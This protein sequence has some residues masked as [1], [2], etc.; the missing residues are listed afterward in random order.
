M[1]TVAPFGAT[2]PDVTHHLADVNGTRLHYVSAGTTG[3]PVLL[4]HGWPET[5]WAFRGLI[6]RLAL[7][8]RVVAVD[9]RGFGDSGSGDT[10]YGEAVSAEDLRQLVRHLGAGP[11]HLLCQDISG[12]TGFRFAAGHPEDVLSFTG[13]ETTLAGYGL[14]ALAD[15]NRHGSWHVGFL[16]A[17]G[18]PSMLL[19]G[20]ERELLAGW[21]FPLMSGTEGAITERDVDEFTRTYARPGGWRGTE[22]LYQAVFADGGATRER[23]EARPLQVP[24][25]AVDGAAHPFTENTLRQVSAGEITSVHIE[26]VGHFVAQ[27]APGQLAEAILEFTARVDGSRG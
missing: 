10:E 8:H 21:A 26:G 20:H 19:P 11:V 9:L 27:E 7:H 3:S 15:V 2:L 13:V 12:G 4:V 1:T 16:G 23:A 6:P 24:V 25:L 22:G 17:P 5:W 18:I 14:E